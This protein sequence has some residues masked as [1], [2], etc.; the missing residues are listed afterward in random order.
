MK[1]PLGIDAKLPVGELLSQA[2]QLIYHKRVALF[3][4]LAPLLVFLIGVDLAM[5]VFISAPQETDKTNV[6]MP[7][8]SL[9]TVIFMFISLFFS[10]LYAT[11]S[12][13]FTL[14][15]AAQK[16]QQGLRLWG[17][18]EANYFFKSIQIGLLSMVVFAL[19]SSALAVIVG[20]EQI[21]I[22]LGLAAVAALYVL[23]RLSIILPEAALG[24]PTNLKR[25]WAMSQGNGTRMLLVVIIVPACMIMPFLL[26]SML[27]TPFINVFVS[28]GMYLGSLVSLVILSL[29]YQFLLEFYETQNPNASNQQTTSKTQDDD[30]FEA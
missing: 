29:S 18:N 7:Q 4:L 5:Q 27:Q 22:A 20:K 14:S 3:K 21:Y 10:V 11:N 15:P 28:L 26:L 30:S 9:M 2:L 6:M 12:H 24:K 13:Q 17:E 19:C 1:S 8:V 25:A 23:S 16:P